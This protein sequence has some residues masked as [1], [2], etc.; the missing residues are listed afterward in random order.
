MRSALLAGVLTLMP[1]AALAQP[2][3]CEPDAAGCARAPIAYRWREGLPVEFDFDTGW[4]PPSSPVQVRIRAVLAGS[5]QVSAAGELVGS[6][7]EPMLLRAVG[8]PG[9]GAL[10]VDYGVVFTARVRL[11][12]EVAGRPVGW[13]GPI[14]Y[15]PMI[16]FRAMAQRT[17][18][19]WGWSPV[20]AEGRTAR[21]RVA[22]VPITD[23]IVRI[24]GISGGFTFEAAGDVSA[25]Y[26]STRFTFG[27]AAEPLDAMNTRTLAV[28]NAGPFVEYQPRLE[29]DLAYRGAIH[30][31]PGLYVSLAGRRWMLDLVDLP[32]P[33]GPFPRQVLFDP[34]VAH[35]GLPDVRAVSDVVDFG[36]VDVGRMSER[37][38]EIRNDGEGDGRVLGAAVEAPFGVMTRMTSLPVRS[39]SSFIASFT[40][41]RPGPI[42]GELVITT[43]DPDTPRVRVR[44][45]ANGVATLMPPVVDDAGFVDDVADAGAADASVAPTSGAQ[46]GS[47]GCR[48]R[49]T[50]AGDGAG[51]WW[52]FAGATLLARRRARRQ[53]ATTSKRSL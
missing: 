16:D 32:I 37:T 2:G 38:V 53:G 28:F 50:A 33:I 20:T 5:T 25:A 17:F 42:T 12:L 9:Q 22:D 21:V 1:A 51:A 52:L 46:D 41:V 4:V 48:A 47:C 11:A 24:P 7:P 34:A 13:E 29:G 14:P 49:G 18:D 15:V 8:A 6:W 43:N 44:L 31:Y 30:I 10:S 26:R 45:R 39:R 23:A 36:D 35:L 27:T 19:P 40:P 3:G